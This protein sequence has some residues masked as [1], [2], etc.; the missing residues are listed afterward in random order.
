MSDD[1]KTAGEGGTAAAAASVPTEQPYIDEHTTEPNAPAA[2]A[3]EPQVPSGKW[4]MPKPKFQQT[5]GYLPQGY[6]K[7]SGAEP[8]A[9]Q[10]PTQ[11]PAPPASA[12]PAPAISEATAVEPQPDLM[13]LIP[14]EPVPENLPSTAPAKSSSPLPFLAVLL[15][16]GAVLVVIVLLVIYIVFF[17]NSSGSSIF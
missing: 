5:S 16:V 13:Q 2:A 7:Q 8:E 11:Q 14:D 6:V 12:T 1:E 3:T 4:Q 9:P 10:Q 15:V 17:S